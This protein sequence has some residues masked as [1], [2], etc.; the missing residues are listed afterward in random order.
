MDPRNRRSVS[1][2]LMLARS[3]A[4]SVPISGS[5]EPDVARKMFQYLRGLSSLLMTSL[6]VNQE[7][8]GLT[9]GSR[10]PE[11]YDAV[12][13]VHDLTSFNHDQAPTLQSALSSIINILESTAT[14]QLDEAILDALRDMQG[15]RAH[16]DI[17]E[18]EIEERIRQTWP[19]LGFETGDV[20]EVIRALNSERR[21]CI[22]HS[23]GVPSQYRIRVPHGYD[24]AKLAPSAA[25]SFHLENDVDRIKI[26][27]SHSSNDV[28]LATL[29]VNC[30]N[31]SLVI[32]DGTMLC[33]SVAGYRL[34]AGDESGEV[35]RESIAT[36]SIVVGVLTPS[37]LA[38]HYVIMELGAGWGLQ[39]TVCALLGPGVD[40][41]QIPGPLAG[42]HA[43]VATSPP[44][45][46]NLVDVISRHGELSKRNN[47]ARIAAAISAFVDT[48]RSL[49]HSEPP[50][51]DSQ[52]TTPMKTI[53]S[54]KDAF[55]NLTSWMRNR[56]SGMNTRAISFSATDAELG[57]APGLTKKLIA[58]AAA[59][60]Y[61]VAQSGD[62]FILFRGK[63]MRIGASRL[64]G[65]EDF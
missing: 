25:E 42:R 35:L 64:S 22:K 46:A 10:Y 31:E 8:K 58:Q 52:S 18:T 56:P 61:D 44:D 11:F 50:A 48:V 51:T 16:V 39:K 65:I 59:E 21:L 60:Y 63:P 20:A 17:L 32:P 33:T 14:P 1:E 15:Q 62:D 4:G 24:S 12:C 37:S 41:R 38:S 5:S 45:V 9:A 43:V 47:S 29:L 7:L 6:D 13:Y 49:P 23:E 54:E 53:S 2:I 36:C 30:L 3:A 26:F 40:F 28:E 55:I 34:D 19:R 27:V 57:L